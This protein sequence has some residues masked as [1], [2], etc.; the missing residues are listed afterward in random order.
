MR[1]LISRLD[2]KKVEDK[3]KTSRCQGCNKTHIFLIFFKK[4]AKQ[5]HTAR[6]QMPNLELRKLYQIKNIWKEHI[7]FGTL[8]LA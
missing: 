6:P 8:E 2:F 5:K 1:Y 3:R 7:R 4:L